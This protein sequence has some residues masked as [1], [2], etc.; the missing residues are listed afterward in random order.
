[1][2]NWL[3]AVGCALVALLASLPFTHAIGEAGSREGTGSTKF[4][5]VTRDSAKTPQ[6]LETAVVSYRKSPRFGLF[7]SGATV[8]LVATVHIA[9]AAYFRSLNEDLR[10][11]DAV[12][13]ELIVDTG[14]GTVE[15]DP[16]INSNV[17]GSLQGG[18]RDM[19]ALEHQNQYLDYSQPN[20]VHADMTLEQFNR[21]SRGRNESSFDLL[22]RLLEKSEALYDESEELPS[23]DYAQA[24]GALLDPRQRGKVFKQMLASQFENVDMM[25]EAVNGSNGSTII[26]ERNRV[27]LKKLDEQLKRGAKRIAIL[28]G[29]GHMSDFESRLV[30]DFGFKKVGS[31]WRVAWDLR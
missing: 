27:A 10:A 13:Y 23:L 18:M 16:I 20:M 26:T 6:T 24:L 4:V 14:E 3:L 31:A 2:R 28:Y 1:M 11:Y 9:D 5:R 21:V 17:I 22:L 8:D 7:G 15:S 29:A 19:L 12:L 25:S 30:Q